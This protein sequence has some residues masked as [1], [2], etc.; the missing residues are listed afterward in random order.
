MSASATKMMRD[1]SQPTHIPETTEMM[2]ARTCNLRKT[3]QT[4]TRSN[5]RK[6]SKKP[7]NDA[8]AMTNVAQ[9]MREPSQPT[10][11]VLDTHSRAGAH[12]TLGTAITF[13]APHVGTR[14]IIPPNKACALS[15]VGRA[16][17]L[18]IKS[19]QA[20]KVEVQVSRGPGMRVGPKF[21]GDPK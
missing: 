7:Q 8:P 15:V 6:F 9:T 4:V 18:Q 13:W 11:K 12:T 20:V 16:I 14:P 1:A 17:N 10:P 2:R 5:T 3:K 19:V 21:Q